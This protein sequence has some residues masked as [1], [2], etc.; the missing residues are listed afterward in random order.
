MDKSTRYK[1]F[2]DPVHGF[3][4]VPKGIILRLIDHPYIQR[5]RRIRQLGLGYLVFPAAEH[6]RFSHALG[7]L[8]LA[9]RVLNNLLE[10][11]TTIT[12]K[13][14]EGT[15]IAILLHD[16]GHGPLSHTLE[17]SL[18]KDF[19]HEM[20]SLTIM[21]ELNQEFK[22]ELDTAIA[23]FTNQYKKKF[24]HQLISSQLDLDRLDY[25]SRDSFFTGVSEGRIGINRILKTMRV[26]KGNIVIEKKGIYAIENYIIARRLMYMQVY[27]HKTVLSADALIRSVFKRVRDLLDSGQHL[28][29]ASESLRFFME[30]QPS[31][32]KQITKKMMQAYTSLDDY[33]IYLNIKFWTQSNDKILAE[34]CTR[35]LNRSLFRTTFFENQPT[36]KEQEEIHRQT[37]LS[38]KK[39]GL[40]Y[41]DE[42]AAY[43]YSFDQSYSEAYKYQNESIW[44]LEDENAVEFSKAADTKNIIALTEPV[45]KNYCVHL[46]EIKI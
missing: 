23:I 35:F 36:N 38:L 26:H 8:E 9:K 4:T 5:L 15:L 30:D 28:D 6:S 2:N 21:K 18:I 24:L 10:K 33:D 20:M 1:I 43:F 14:Y 3:I 32:K 34:L 46:K 7:A 45:V 25:L 17:H 27:L 11:D 29:F 40:P 31:A 44:I 42:A 37:K 19:N 16:V 12:K 39:L 22:G 41:G 13:E